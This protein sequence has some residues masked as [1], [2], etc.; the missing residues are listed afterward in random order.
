MYIGI[1]M[2]KQGLHYVIYFLFF[3][4]NVETENGGGSINMITMMAFQDGPGALFENANISIEQTKSRKFF[5]V[6]IIF[7][8]K[9]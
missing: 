4:Y 6:S 8:L 5:M 2:F 9:L 3:S 7:F 1:S